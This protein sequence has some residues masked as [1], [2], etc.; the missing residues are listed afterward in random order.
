MSAK[1]GAKYELKDPRLLAIYRVEN[2]DCFWTSAY[3]N[4]TCSQSWNW[5]GKIEL[6]DFAYS[7]RAKGGA[8]RGMWEAILEMGSKIRVILTYHM[9]TCI[10]DCDTT[11]Y[12]ISLNA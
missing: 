4:L 3:Q 7:G 8:G 10:H 1:F 9:C 12:A 6:V 5:T 11:A 2:V